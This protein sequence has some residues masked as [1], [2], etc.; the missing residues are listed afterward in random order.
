MR[1][2]TIL[3]A[4]LMA[5][6]LFPI[7]GIANPKA[8]VDTPVYEFEAVPE[9]PLIDAEFVIKNNGSELL[10]IEKVSPP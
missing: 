2:R 1:K 5:L 6:L 3:M 10:V 7:Q 4:L 8:V 9:G